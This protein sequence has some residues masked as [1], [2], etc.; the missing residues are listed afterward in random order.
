MVVV[1]AQFLLIEVIVH[2]TKD[3]IPP[4]VGPGQFT[5]SSVVLQES[6]GPLSSS[7][8]ELHGTPVA[9]LNKAKLEAYN[10]STG[11]VSI[12]EVSHLSG[13]TYKHSPANTSALVISPIANAPMPRED[14]NTR[15]HL[16]VKKLVLSHSD[17]GLPRD[18]HDMVYDEPP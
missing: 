6:G 7:F 17:F 12:S 10:M 2:L 14:S 5:L 9:S 16:W 3:F 8:T 11:H 15:S 4:V 1:R 18:L 13:T